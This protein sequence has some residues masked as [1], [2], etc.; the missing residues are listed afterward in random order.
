MPYC[1]NC[2]TPAD[3]NAVAC[4]NCGTELVVSKDKKKNSLWKKI[5]KLNFKNIAILIGALAVIILI[6]VFISSLTNKHKKAIDNYMD[7]TYKAKENAIESLIPGYLWDELEEEYNTDFDKIVDIFEKKLD[8]EHE[9]IEKLYGKNIKISYRIDDTDEVDSDE[10]GDIKD[11]LK[12]YGIKKKDVKKALEVD[13]DL[14]IRGS[15]DED[16][17]ETELILVKIKGNWYVYD[18]ITT[19]VWSA[20]WS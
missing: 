9:K 1:H 16:V 5:K 18:A 10:L 2:G 6:C 8:S 13:L 3:E 17:E 19:I 4:Q 14:R 20:A 15:E 12:Q 7:A 11:V